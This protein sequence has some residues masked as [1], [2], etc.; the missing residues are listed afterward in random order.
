METVSHAS[1]PT[2]PR[3]RP[4]C[5]SYCRDQRLPRL[6]PTTRSRARSSTAFLA[7]VERDQLA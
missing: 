5:I 1:T 4:Y 7:A 3:D 6:P 2:S